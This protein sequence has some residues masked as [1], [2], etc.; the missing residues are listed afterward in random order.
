MRI[1]YKD[2]GQEFAALMQEAHKHKASISCI[3][4]TRQELTA[5]FAHTNANLF[6]SDY[7][8]PRAAK[9]RGLDQALMALSQKLERVTTQAERQA[10]FDERTALERQKSDLVDGVPNELTQNGVRIKVTMNG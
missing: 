10:V 6:F 4:V 3:N 5:L 7:M 8:G 9:V 2:I 1:I